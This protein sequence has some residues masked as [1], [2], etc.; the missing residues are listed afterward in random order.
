[1]TQPSELTSL[2][3]QLVS[4]QREDR[5]AT[6]ARLTAIQREAALERAASKER[7]VGLLDRVTQRT[8]TQFQQMQ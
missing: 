3:Q 5:Q 1:M 7:F 6:E 2:L 8:D 4:Q